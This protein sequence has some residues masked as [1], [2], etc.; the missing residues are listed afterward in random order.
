MRKTTK[1]TKEMTIGEVIKKYPKSIFVFIDY[2]LHCVGCPLAQ[3]DTLE[4]AAKIHRLDLDKLLE[5]LKAACLS[6]GPAC[7]QAGRAA[8]K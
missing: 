6:A 4:G 2:G 8:K 5:D 3:N 1:I 7:R